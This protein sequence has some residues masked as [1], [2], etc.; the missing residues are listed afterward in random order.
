MDKETTIVTHSGGFHTD[1]VFAV[2]TLALFLGDKEYKVIRSRDMKVI[3]KADLVVDVGNIYDPD[4]DRFDHHQSEGGAGKRANGIPYSSFGL[5][6]KK[7]GKE[8]CD[9]KQVALTVEKR[10]VYPIDA[11]DNGVDTYIKKMED[12]VPYTI[13]NIVEVFHPTWK[14]DEN[15]RNLDDAFLEAVSVAKRILAREIQKARDEKESEIFVREAYERANDKRIIVI[16][17][18]HPWENALKNYPEPLYV[19]KP[20]HQNGDSWKIKAVRD[21]PDA[22][23]TNRKD[24]PIAWAGKR[25]TELEEITGVV[26]AVFCH[27]KLFIAVAGS[28]EGALQLAKLAVEN[29][30]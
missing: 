5:V 8:L 26:E 14:E 15:E 11:V 1:D 28:K 25:D 12:V 29:K 10:L 19:V 7:F 13:H 3:E 17:G 4:K 20:D 23:F 30:N 6:W 2:A 16:D 22:S 18:H 21:D 24:L 27:S 9:S